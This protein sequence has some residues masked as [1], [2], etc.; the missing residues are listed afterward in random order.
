[1]SKK[2]RYPKP[3]K[4]HR[5]PV[6]VSEP[7]LLEE[8]PK[9]TLM[10]REVLAEFRPQM[11]VRLTELIAAAEQAFHQGHAREC[12]VCKARMSSRGFKGLHY[13]TRFGEIRVA[14]R[15]YRCEVCHKQGLKPDE[16]PF[17]AY[18]GVDALGR[19]SGAL[20]RL[21]ALLA[22]V[23][24]FELARELVEELL[25]VR[26]STMTVWRCVQRLGAAQHEHTQDL[27]AYHQHPNTD[28]K[29]QPDKVQSVVMLGVDGGALGMQVHP[30]RRK[31]PVNG[32]PL[33]PLPKVEEGHFREV[34]TGVLYLAQDRTSS[35]P[36]RQDLVK[37]L[38]VTCL[39]NAD[40]AFGLLWSK[41]ASLGWMGPDT[42][43][44]VLGDG[45]EWIW[46]RAK[47]FSNRCEILDFWHAVEK[48]WEWARARHGVAS[49][50]AEALMKGIT[51]Q[52]RAGKVVEVIAQLA[53][54]K[55]TSPE[56]QEKLLT[57][58]KYYTDNQSRM[59]YAL[60]V[61]KGYGI[62]SGAVESAHKQLLQARMRQAGMRWSE[63]GARNML[64]LRVLLLNGGWHELDRLA[65]V[66]AAA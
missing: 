7:K 11:Q 23:A 9:L 32:E 20:A 39:G 46:N 2:S 65:M 41:L 30:K 61:K 25:G 52:L 55:A 26:M 13:V 36:G 40:M 17:L 31:A 21:V 14:S 19:V 37:R 59:Q 44:V 38:L 66:R 60:Y 18:L 24:P 33:P 64:A 56:E 8:V 27:A 58:I 22:V 48:G 57:L 6:A 10:E 45:A 16:R 3:C 5:G 1:M 12:S 28:V 29:L 35:R 51:A 43:V 34:K 50:E 54:F 42:V 47:L 63:K 53:G 15:V 49:L 62:G 4:A